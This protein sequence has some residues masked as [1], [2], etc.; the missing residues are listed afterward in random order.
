MHLGDSESLKDF[1]DHQR[2]LIEA[3]FEEDYAP[4]RLMEDEISF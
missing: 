2:G 3:I 4:S 1:T